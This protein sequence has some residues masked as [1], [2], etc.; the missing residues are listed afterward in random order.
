MQQHESGLPVRGATGRRLPVSYARGESTLPG[1]LDE[2]PWLFRVPQFSDGAGGVRARYMDTAGNLGDPILSHLSEALTCASGMPLSKIINMKGDCYAHF[3]MAL[4]GWDGTDV[5]TCKEDGEYY[6]GEALG[7]PLVSDFRDSQTQQVLKPAKFGR[8]IGGDDY[9]FQTMYVESFL[10]HYMLAKPYE[11]KKAD[12]FR[13]QVKTL[14]DLSGMG[15]IKRQPPFEY[16]EMVAARMRKNI[17]YKEDL[18]YML[19]EPKPTQAAQQMANRLILLLSYSGMSTARFANNFLKKNPK[20][21]LLLIDSIREEAVRF[22]NVFGP[23]AADPAYKWLGF[24]EKPIVRNLRSVDYPNLFAAAVEFRKAEV[25]GGMQNYEFSVDD[26][27]V[28]MDLI[29][30]LVKN[31]VN[32]IGTGLTQNGVAEAVQLGFDPQVLANFDQRLRASGRSMYD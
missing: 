8:G 32:G 16:L 9:D 12:G 23:I 21:Q 31:V 30:R 5:I 1:I 27:T 14:M 28:S 29:K 26:L 15:V 3:M 20:P 24:L 13:K 11:A 19:F 6:N 4:L 2:D 17:T 7:R 10:V 18:I 22:Q 25:G